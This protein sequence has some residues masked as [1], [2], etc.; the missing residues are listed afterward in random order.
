SIVS[1]SSLPKVCRTLV[2]AESIRLAAIKQYVEDEEEEDPIEDLGEEVEKILKSPRIMYKDDVISI[3]IGIYSRPQK[4]RVSC[5]ESPCIVDMTTSVYEIASVNAHLPYAA[6]M[7]LLDIPAVEWR[8][9]DDRPL[10]MLLSGASGSG[11]RLLA[12]RL[13]M[14][15]HR[16]IV[17]EC[18]YNL[19]RESVDQMEAN[20]RNAFEKAKSYQPSILY[21]TSV[22]VLGY[23][24]ASGTLGKFSILF[25]LKCHVCLKVLLITTYKIMLLMTD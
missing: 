3:H 14:E 16:N 7:K 9:V 8:L 19:W 15:T 17:E 18:S 1:Y 4:G 21:L 24:P 6:R 20:L 5:N 13:A 11:K 10:T 2:S 25:I 22:D 23:D 12:T